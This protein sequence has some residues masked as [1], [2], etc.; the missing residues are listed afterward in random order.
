MD[1][2][3]QV[4][5][6]LD[7]LPKEERIELLAEI[8]PP[9]ELFARTDGM[10]CLI[11]AFGLRTFDISAMLTE[12]GI[13]ADDPR[14]TVFRDLRGG[15]IDRK[16]PNALRAI[17]A[18][19]TTVCKNAGAIQ[20][21]HGGRKAWWVPLAASSKFERAVNDLI[22]EFDDKRD[23]LLLEQYPMIKHRARERWAEAS[24]AAYRNLSRLD[25]LN[26]VSRDEFMARLMSAFENRFPTEKDIR[27][28]IRMELVPVERPL[29][30]K[31]ERI[32]QDVRRAER[33]RQ[34]AE[35]E[36]A[37]E[38]KR[39]LALERTFREQEM[40]KLEDERHARERLL[41]EAIDPQMK[42]AQEI[43]AQIQ[44]SLVR[45]A[46]EIT[47]S[48]NSD[49]TISPATRR[50]WSK[51]LEAL[52]H[53]APGN[54]PLERALE[55]LRRLAKDPDKAPDLDAEVASRSVGDALRDL[56]R[57]ASTEVR[58]DLIWQLMREGK[59]EEALRRV[60]RLREHLTDNLSEVEALWEMVV[61][62]GAQN[63]V[64]DAETELKLA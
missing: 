37:R 17:A 47:D 14:A 36:A 48:L 58:A 23:R 31:V 2:Y 4:Y 63:Q 59:G 9:Q 45:V 34:E 41:R 11:R 56:E 49:A 1:I 40:R 60:A 7:A 10:R 44:S 46:Q 12:A 52:S 22:K 64:L 5:E 32:L 62:V 54:V 50:S 27:E 42:Q 57:R 6:Q 29:P 33:E 51:R 30:E 53:L 3:R 19:A 61:E 16:I 26:G 18:R 38:Q 24:R 55:D 15:L 25:S 28:K 35:A 20:V 39:L 21:W 13:P 43:V 8:L